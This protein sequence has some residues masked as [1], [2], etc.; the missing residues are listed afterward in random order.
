LPFLIRPTG[1][2]SAEAGSS[3]PPARISSAFRGRRVWDEAVARGFAATYPSDEAA[4]RLPQKVTKPMQTFFVQ[5]KCELGRTYEVAQA[6]ADQE[7]HSEVYSTA[8]DYD[9]IVKYHLEDG[10]DVGQFVGRH[11]QTVAGVR[12]TYMLITFKAF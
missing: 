12:D 7:R 3:P 1:P 11:V 2:L 8:G 10:V 6:L 4:G 9:L 5:I